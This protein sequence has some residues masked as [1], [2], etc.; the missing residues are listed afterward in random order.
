M[1]I[2]FLGTAAATACPLVFCRCPVCREAWRKGGPD[3]RRRS[4]VLI[5]EDL[6]IDLGPD[7]MS[8]AFDFGV[9]VSGIRFLL[10]T[11]SHS[12]HFNAGHLITRMPD[13]A[14]EDILPLEVCASP[15]TLRHM[16]EYLALEE[17]GADLLLPEWQERLNLSV[18]SM[19]HGDMLVLGNRRITAAESNHDLQDGSLLY[20]IEEEGKTFFYATDTMRLTDRTWKLFRERGFAFDAVAIDT[21]YGPGTHGGG[22]LSA[23]QAA[24]EIARLR[25]EGVLKPGGRAFATHISHEGMPLHR[26]LDQYAKAH[27]FEAARD[28]LSLEI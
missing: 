14:T 27:G 23:D 26:E 9:D 10:Q 19:R 28:G 16:S 21:T 13:Y 4:S 15:E 6:L 18:H 24:E 12:D 20:I 8:S 1:K 5:G 17:P 11:H 22:H 7:V 2:T 3:F 25:A